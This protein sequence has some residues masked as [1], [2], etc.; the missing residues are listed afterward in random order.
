MIQPSPN[1]NVPPADAPPD[2]PASIPEADHLVGK[3]CP[4]V[5]GVEKVTGLALYGADLFPHTADLFAKVV[6]SREAHADIVSIDT[7]AALAVTGVVGV[8]THVDVGGT[9][10]HGLIRRDHP[11]LASKRVR[12]RGDAIAI[13]V[14]ESERAAETARDLVEV[15]YD[16]LPVVA[17]ID[18]ALADGAPRLHPDGNV[19]GDKRIRKGE[20]DTALAH[21][22]VVVSETF[23]T[24]T[25]DHAFLDLEA[26][27]AIWDGDLLTL[28]TA[29]QWIHEERRLIALALGLPVE[30]I[31]IIQP[32]TGG[33]FGGREDISIQ[34]YVGL[35]A[36]KHPGKTVALRYTREESMRARHKR[37]A[38][39]IAYT[40]GADAEGRLTAA[41]VVVHSD[42]G[43]YASTGIAVMRKASS[44]ATGPYRVPNVSVDVYGVHTNNNPTG[45]MRG[46]GACQMAIAYEGMMDRLAAAL[47]MD[48]VALREKNLIRPGD[49]VTTGQRIENAT[50]LECLHAALEK[51]KERPYPAA[52]LPPRLRR[53]WG[54]SVICF[55]LGYGDGF[56]DC[57]RARVKLNEDGSAT[58]YTGGVE[59]GQGLLN[60]VMQIAGEELG[61]PFDRMKVVAADTAQ[62]DESGSSSATRQTYFTGSAVRIAAGELR[63]QIL[64]I[65]G[66]RLKVHPHEVT[67]QRGWAFETANRA[68]RVALARVYQDGVTRGY[69]LSASGLFKP[70]TI[71]EKRDTGQ[72]PRAFITYLFGAHVSQVLVD[73]ETGEIRVERHIAAHDVGKAI[74]PQ[75][76]AGQIAG[77]VAQGIGM[78]LME[79]VVYRNGRIMNPG[80]T[81][82]IVPTVKDVPPVEAVIVESDDPGGPFGAHGIGEPPLIGAVPA[83]LAAIYDATGAAP[84]TLP[85]HPERMWRLLREKE[86]KTQAT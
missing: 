81:D 8:Y 1:T 7:R 17:T 38:L 29:G 15:R 58:V 45:A 74:N 42:E 80:F 61:L 55:G 59:V 68:N 40:L 72:S 48:R 64:D 71:A 14:A 53:G 20:C 30:Q 41:R 9:N 60:T 27:T 33:A 5:D 50:A 23:N 62:T 32:A 3:S 26:G 44:H 69:S 4:R 10:V 2:A 54:M 28:H 65:A 56:P 84:H 34:I 86:G 39:R 70:R 11:A 79:E 63:E 57:S 78:A 49:E 31:R 85:A 25:V 22:H 46:F 37:H 75:S 51:F 18:D 76:V 52:P 66:Q 36:L 6:R 43:A 21:S 73:I 83:I 13:I 82:Y 47:G 24:Q 12:Y 67:L 35:A 77:G 16:P 19:M